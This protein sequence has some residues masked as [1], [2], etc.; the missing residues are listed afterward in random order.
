MFSSP[1][2]THVC[3]S[4]Q[5][6]LHI[7]FEYDKSKFHLKD[8]IC[9]E[10]HFMLVRI[11]IKFMEIE[12]RRLEQPSP[13]LQKKKTLSVFPLAQTESGVS[14]SISACPSALDATRADQEKRVRRQ[15]THELQRGGNH[16][17]IRSHGR[18]AC[19]R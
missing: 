10:I 15:W 6:C 17:E 18:S 3:V 4:M 13:P 12:V 14:I 8:T 1:L 2:G 11:R 16:I 19:T 9:G 7:E 5:D